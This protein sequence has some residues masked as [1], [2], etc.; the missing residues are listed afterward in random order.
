MGN[1][2]FP[3]ERVSATLLTYSSTSRL[4]DIIL[5]FLCGVGL[6]LLLLPYLPTCRSCLKELQEAR[7][8]ISLLRNHIEKRPDKGSFHQG[9]CR[10]PSGGVHEREP[11]ET[12]EPCAE[13]LDDAAPVVPPSASTAPQPQSPRTLISTLSPDLMTPSVSDLSP[14]LS[15][16]PPPEPPLPLDSLS[17]PPL[18]LPPPPPH[19][20]D[21]FASLNPPAA[22]SASPPSDTTLTL[23]RCDST[24]MALPLSSAQVSASPDNCW[25]SCVPGITGLDHTSH[26]I[27]TVPWW[28]AAAK[29][30]CLSTSKHFE[31]PQEHTSCHPQEASV[32]GDATNRQVEAASSVFFDPDVQKLL[33]IQITKRAALKIWKEKEKEGSDYHL[34]SLKNMLKTFGDE[35][36]IVH[37]QP[38]WNTSIKPE[39]LPSP[40]KPLHPEAL[41]DRLQQKYSQLF[42]GLPFL[43]S[44]SLV[45]TVRVS[46]STLELPSLLFNGISNALPIQKQAKE[47]PLFLQPQPLPDPEAQSQLL[48]PTMPPPQ[49]PILTQAHP[50]SSVP[51]ALPSSTSRTRACEES[52]LTIPNE[53]QSPIPNVIRYLECHFLK[54]QMESESSLP[55]MVQRSQ[56]ALSSLSLI[57]PQD[58]WASQT[59]KSDSILPGDFISPE[60]RKQLEQHLQERFIQQQ[61]G[62]PSRIQESLELMQ[63]LGKLPG[64]CQA[65]DQHGL[66]R[67]SVHPGES[68]KN[69]KKSRHPGR[70]RHS[71][72]FHVCHRANTQLEKDLA[73]DLRHSLRKVPKYNT[74]QGSENSPVRVLGADSE[75]SERELMRQSGIDSGNYK[76]RDSNKK[77]LENT[78]TVHL[79]RK[80]EQIIEGQ[81]PM[82]VRRS[83]LAASHTLP[84]SDTHVEIGNLAFLQAQA[85][86]MNTTQ[87]LPFFDPGT[88]QMLEAHM[89]RFRMRHR[90]CLPLKALEPINLFK[91]RK[92]H[93]SPLLQSAFPCSATHESWADLRAEADKFL[94]E[95][96]QS[97]L[98]EK[99]TPRKPIPTLESPLPAPSPVGKELQGS[100][101]QTPP[102]NDPRPSEVAQSGQEGRQP[103]QPLTPSIV[104][105]AS[106]SRTV[107]GAQRGSLEPTRSQ[108]VTRKEP[109]EESRSYALGGPCPSV[110]R[111]E[112]SYESQS[113][114]AEETREMVVVKRS[115]ELQLQD[116]DVLRTS[117]LAKSQ[118]INVD[119][120]GL[121]APGTSK[122]QVEVGTENGPQGCPTDLLLQ[123]CATDVLLASDILASRA[124][125]SCP[126]GMSSTNMPVSQVLSDLMVAG[127]SS[128]GHQEPK[129]PNLWNTWKSQSKIS[130]PTDERKDFKRRKPKEHEERLAGL[131]ASPASGMSQP[132]QDKTL[133]E[134]LR[135]KSSQAPPEKGQALAEGHF[136][137]RMKHFLQWIFPNKKD[138]GQE[139]H[140]QKE[141]PI[142]ASGQSCGL[143]KSKSVFMDRGAAE[144]Q[145]LMTAVGQILEEKM[146]LQ[147]GLHASKL[148]SQ[149]EIQ[150]PVLGLSSHHR[151]PY[152]EHGRVM[153]DT[154]CHHKRT[155][156]GQSHPTRNRW[157][158]DSCRSLWKSMGFK[159]S[160][161]SLPTGKPMSPVRSQLV[162]KTWGALDHPH[163]CPRH[164]LREYVLSGQLEQASAALLSRKT[165]Q[166]NIQSVPD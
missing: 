13:P 88:L 63:P 21:S 123:D 43:H 18:A 76:L 71:G 98:G 82:S 96:P 158:R 144:A 66:S 80:L 142:S 134:S 89:S 147:Q 122:S 73:K 149:K 155:P 27:S 57:L 105:R 130:A 45:A 111:L 166:E 23:S 58:S 165:I 65:K 138:K 114:G 61:W 59:H 26:P 30:L 92:A 91:T 8:L 107:L 160:N 85:H 125:H 153:S 152:S 46:G 84:K 135:I 131:G 60:L 156:E 68:R 110:A 112:M 81:I 55:S 99:V 54:K 5:A 44:E 39:Q 50:Q 36:D 77:Q 53:A 14:S 124:S 129:I 132:A 64:T 35:Q 20:P 164:C 118:N 41:G 11:A 161:R 9:K 16:S 100:L 74:S 1:S 38:F 157:I 17:P 62:V 139:G 133:V 56:A 126:Q 143:V 22:F 10:D 113:S 31:V 70:S 159:T 146:A 78:L 102:G 47:S 33:E 24:A 117:V 121:G 4:T 103:F 145:A 72:S 86:R 49:A 67:P 116:R 7:S 93:S 6:F 104:G 12:R 25:L 19:P 106:E 137:K 151:A 2:L 69:I 97:G 108:S 109:G 95:N 42:W 37:P 29:T 101:R 94:G 28:R 150:A 148:S 140:P 3:L 128:L 32:W 52:C 34:N 136:K 40:Q 119:L 120:R 141:K 75:E 87:E 162:P 79:G 115:S 127:K 51:T 154:A 83:W 15:A 48:T 90:W 163:H